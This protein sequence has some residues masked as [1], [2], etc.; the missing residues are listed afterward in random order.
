MPGRGARMQR[1]ALLLL[2]PNETPGLRQSD[3]DVGGICHLRL[4]PGENE[5]RATQRLSVG[6][7][8]VAVTPVGAACGLPLP[9]LVGAG[10][11]IAGSGG[12]CLPKRHCA[13][14]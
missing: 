8:I 6:A 7:L 3:G 1:T 14:N 5:L 4:R 12:G 13:N 10:G 11:D 2:L 9:A